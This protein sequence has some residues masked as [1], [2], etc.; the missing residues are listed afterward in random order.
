[1]LG[2]GD[3]DLGGPEVS[4]LGFRREL[5]FGPE[6]GGLDVVKISSFGGSQSVPCVGT[7]APSIH[8]VF[9]CTHCAQ[10]SGVSQG[11]G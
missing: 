5:V 1:M 6:L 11:M 3:L 4:R 10:S 9:G 7:L 2:W 8:V